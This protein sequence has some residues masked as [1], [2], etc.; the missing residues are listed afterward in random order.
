[1]AC[2][3]KIIKSATDEGGDEEADKEKTGDEFFGSISSTWQSRIFLFCLDIKDDYIVRSE[4][5][6]GFVG[7]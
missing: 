3:L 6:F 5:G 4:M 2:V 7:K 1:M